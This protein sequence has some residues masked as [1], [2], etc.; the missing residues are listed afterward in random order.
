MS[1]FAD[2]ASEREE[3]DRDLALKAAH[4]HA[5]A[6]SATGYCHN[7]EAPLPEGLRF[8]DCDCRNDYDSRQRAA[9]LK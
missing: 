6:L 9:R 8:C 1:D 5:P 7:C 3:L 4:N 2:L